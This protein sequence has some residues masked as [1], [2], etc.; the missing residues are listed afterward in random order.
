[1]VAEISQIRKQ[2]EMSVALNELKITE[3]VIAV[4]LVGRDGFVIEST[5]SSALDMEALGA[6]V[7][8]A[9]G[10]TESLGMEFELGAMDQYLAEFQGG[11]VLMAAVHADILAVVTEASAVI[12][13]VRY[14]MRKHI[15]SVL[16]AML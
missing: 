9:I 11:K 14:A 5:A 15:P 4:A 12:G 16:K 10:T 1:M 2:S 3:G 7:A 8:T 6:M 13:A